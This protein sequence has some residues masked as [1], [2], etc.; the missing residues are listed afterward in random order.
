MKLL[1]LFLLVFSLPLLNN[2]NMQGMDNSL[3]DEIKKDIEVIKSNDPAKVQQ[4]LLKAFGFHPS[5]FLDFSKETVSDWMDFY[6]CGRACFLKDPSKIEE[7]NDRLIGMRKQNFY[8]IKSTDCFTKRKIKES[9][10][11]TS[12]KV[13]DKNTQYIDK[14]LNFGIMA[15]RKKLKKISKIPSDMIEETKCDIDVINSDNYEQI[16]GYIANEFSLLYVIRDKKYFVEKCFLK[17]PEKLGRVH[18]RLMKM[19]TLCLEKFMELSKLSSDKDQN[20]L[21]DELDIGKAVSFIE[22]TMKMINKQ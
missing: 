15:T 7:A 22:K 12:I 18:Y 6:N 16:V 1:N 13:H 3:A 2:T 17:S 10:L 11:L 8:S 5:F 20:E 19:F 9:P 21:L 14:L 4:R